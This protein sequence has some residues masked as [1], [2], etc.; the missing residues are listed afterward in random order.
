M[1]VNSPGRTNARTIEELI[2]SKIR[3]G[4]WAP[5]SRLPTERELSERFNAARNTIRKALANLEISGAIIRQVGQGTYVAPISA[6]ESSF[7]LGKG[8]IGNAQNHSPAEILDA[9]LFIEPGLAKVLVARA[10]PTDLQTIEDCYNE[11]LSA[12]ELEEFE[13]WDARFHQAVI[14]ATHNDILN[15]LYENINRARLDSEW[16]QIKKKS[17]TLKRR[18]FYNR[19]HLKIL[20]A[21]KDRDAVEL[22]KAVRT[23]LLHV[24]KMM[25]GD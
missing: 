16:G 22:E 15:S 11:C 17:D 21:L 5:N 4:V 1:N 6:S 18:A 19:E 7:Q 13:H 25:L 9:R 12:E 10:T 8:N 23:H 2:M 24:R 3:E 20:L 14:E